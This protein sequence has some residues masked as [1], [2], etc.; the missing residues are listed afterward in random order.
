MRM[1]STYR[2]GA[3]KVPSQVPRTGPG[4]FAFS[5]FRVLFGPNVKSSFFSWCFP[6]GSPK[7]Q[8]NSICICKFIH[9]CMFMYVGR[10][11][12]YWRSSYVITEAE[13]SQDL[14]VGSQWPRDLGERM[15]KFQSTHWKVWDRMEASV[16]AEAWGEGR[17]RVPAPQSGGRDSPP[18]SGGW[19]VLSCSGL[20]LMGWG[21]HM[22]EDNLLYSFHQFK[23]RPHCCAQNYL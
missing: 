2:P 3:G 18:L 9:V 7:K 11:I 8:T 19:V 12:D 20:Q 21:P 22:R 10:S 16:S 17:T 1:D 13:K 23:K 6:Q 14:Q 4:I 5:W 15:V